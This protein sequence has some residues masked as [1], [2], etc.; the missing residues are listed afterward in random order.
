M[1]DFTFG[2]V[3]EGRG[4]G[5]AL[6]IV[7]A[8]PGMDAVHVVQRM[9][10]SSFGWSKGLGLE[11]VTWNRFENV[12]YATQEKHPKV[13][14]KVGLDG[15]AEALVN[16]DSDPASIPGALRQ[17]DMAGAYYRAGDQGL[18][19]LSEDVSAIHW[20]GFN[21]SVRSDAKTAILADMPEG[22]TFTPDGELMIL[23]GEPNVLEVYTSVGECFWSPFQNNTK[24]LR[25]SS[26]D[27]DSSG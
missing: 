21:G 5:W 18:Y 13:I 9:N 14:W 16:L 6:T 25:G 1:H 24:Y 22:L 23:V 11:G 2:I 19:V 8:W 26:Q 27:P 10:L 3:E 17:G 4:R 20:V 12:F 7:E 15:Q